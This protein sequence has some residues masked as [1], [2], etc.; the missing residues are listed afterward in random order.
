MEEFHQ[1]V[2]VNVLGTFHVNKA[3]IG[4]M[5]AQNYG[6]IANI[7]SIAGKDCNLN[8]GAYSSSKAGLI[9]FTNSLG[10]ELAQLDIAVNCV[11]LAAA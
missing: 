5:R 6:R 9:G 4:G 11:T 8:A 1:L 10:K 3:V 2:A 7:A